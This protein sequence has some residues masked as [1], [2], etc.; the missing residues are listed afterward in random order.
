MNISV[1]H[2]LLVILVVAALTFLTRYLP[3]ALF[4]N[5]ST[6]SVLL[7]DLG[8]ILPPAVI[9]ILLVYCLKSVNFAQTASYVPQ[10]AAMAVVAG[11]HAW[12]RNNL[13]SIG[14]GTLFYMFLIQV[15]WT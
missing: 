9:A 8:R 3:F 13:I 12:K 2:S 14:V 11:L 7:T 6:P 15:V 10:I 1:A 4:S 5:L